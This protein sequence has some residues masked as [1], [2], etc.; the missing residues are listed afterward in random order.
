MMPTILDRN[1]L[2]LLP[3]NARSLFT[4]LGWQ[5]S[6][7]ADVDHR[8][9]AEST[10]RTLTVAYLAAGAVICGMIVRMERAQSYP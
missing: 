8:H 7:V 10:L 3:C 9:I 2:S 6:V 4:W 1:I 5:L